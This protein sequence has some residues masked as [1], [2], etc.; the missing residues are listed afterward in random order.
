MRPL[1]FP[2]IRH[3]QPKGS[4]M[5]NC[6]KFASCRDV[7]RN[8]YYRKFIVLIKIYEAD[9]SDEKNNSSHIGDFDPTIL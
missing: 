2:K 5:I 9:Q 7:F 1:S 3:K 8:T 4:L 6:I